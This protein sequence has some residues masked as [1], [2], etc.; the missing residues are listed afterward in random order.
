MKIILE[1]IAKKYHGTCLFKDINFTFEK[2]KIYAITGKNGSGKTTLLHIIAGYLTPTQGKVYI[3]Y[4]SE[5]ILGTSDTYHQHL[6]WAAHYIELVEQYSIYESIKFH[7]IFDPLTTDNELNKII[8][9]GNFQDME[10]TLVSHLSSGMKQR[11]KLL[12]AFASARPILL[13]DEPTT[14]LDEE[15][16]SWYLDQI[17]MQNEKIV[18]ISSNL[19]HEYQMSSDFLHIGT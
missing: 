7:H 5:I 10:N 4:H 1:N 14:N 12:L 16:I 2:G 18:I 17:N 8:K 15:N 19:P 9:R 13:L 6:S 3:N 11:L